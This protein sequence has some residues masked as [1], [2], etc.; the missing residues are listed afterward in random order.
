[1]TIKHDSM[2]APGQGHAGK[3]PDP[4]DCPAGLLGCPSERVEDV[5]CRT[6][7]DCEH[8][9]TCSWGGYCERTDR[10]KNWA[11]LALEQDFGVVATTGGCSI[12]SQ[13]NEGYGCYR[14]DGQQYNGSAVP[15][16]EPLGVGLAPTRVVVGYERLVYYDTSF[17]VRVGWAVRGEGPTPT[18][19]AAFVPVSVALRATHWFGAD[20]LARTGVRAYGFVTGGYGMFD[21]KTSTHVREDPTKRV[22]QGGNDLEQD[23]VLWK[24]AGDAFVGVGAGLSFAFTVGTAMFLDVA[25]V[26]CFP[27]GALI[28]SPNAGLT[29]G[30]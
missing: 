16:N 22:Y 20:P 12:Y 24:R 26:D 8:G 28:V 27:F 6:D 30:F 11:S 19:G 15:T 7:R 3:C 1:V 2:L 23:V 21:V 4:N 25:V 5:P 17:G 18:A 13:E 10:R 14:A 29:L 9:M